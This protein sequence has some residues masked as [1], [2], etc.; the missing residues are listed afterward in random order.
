MRDK[1]SMRVS[2]S[3]TAERVHCPV[4]SSRGGGKGQTGWPSRNLS[5]SIT[6][7]RIRPSARVAEAFVHR[8]P[9]EVR[10]AIPSPRER[11]HSRPF[12]RSDRGVHLSSSPVGSLPCPSSSY[13]PFTRN[14]TN[15]DF[16]A[17][18]FRF[19][20]S[21]SNSKSGKSPFAADVPCKS[22]LSS[23]CPST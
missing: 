18:P 23:V 1:S 8:K 20:V 13:L 7:Y 14:A 11:Q 15:L 3:C 17:L 12:W 5:N 21:R 6:M 16:G 2:S 22:E 9:P 10:K 19:D 4:L